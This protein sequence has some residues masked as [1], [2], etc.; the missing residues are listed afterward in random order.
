MVPA[1]FQSRL[2]WGYLAVFPFWAL[3]EFVGAY[4]EVSLFPFGILVAPI[5][6]K[7]WLSKSL[8][9]FWGKRWNLTFGD[10]FYSSCF[11]P[12]RRRPTLASGLSFF[13][14]GMIHE[15]I[16]SIPLWLVYGKSVFGLFM[17]YFL[18]QFLC[19]A[20]ER[21][22]LRNHKLRPLFTWIVILGPIPLVLNE[23][24]LRVFHFMS[25]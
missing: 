14:S 7:P 3:V 17:I 4:A 24:T 10:W 15:V 16:V 5:N 6:K 1:D 13:A 21:R 12:F 18:V 9:E 25:D 11:V 22:R 20:F 19:V 2:L 8:A 23:G